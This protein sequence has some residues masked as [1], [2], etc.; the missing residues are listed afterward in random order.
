MLHS[1]GSSPFGGTL[2]RRDG[3]V[4][5]TDLES[6]ARKGVGV[7]VSPAVPKFNLYYKLL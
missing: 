7:Q 1:K 3:T 5:N 2:Y 4:D 6:V